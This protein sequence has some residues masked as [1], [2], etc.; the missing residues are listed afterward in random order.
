MTQQLYVRVS[1][2]H[3]VEIPQDAREQLKI[4]PGQKLAV[5]VKD[6]ALYLLPVPTLDDVIG[7]CPGLTY[8]GV[9]EK[10]DRL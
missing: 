8:Q 1:A 10:T 9:R 5:E 3:R 7:L 6:G 2:R 4:R